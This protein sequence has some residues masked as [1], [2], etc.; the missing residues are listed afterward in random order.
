MFGVEFSKKYKKNKKHIFFLKFIFENLCFFCDLEK[1]FQVPRPPVAFAMGTARPRSLCLRTNAC[2]LSSSWA[3]GPVQRGAGKLF[4]EHSCW[5]PTVAPPATSL[6]PPASLRSRDL[7][8][9]TMEPGARSKPTAQAGDVAP[10]LP[11]ALVLP[12]FTVF[13]YWVQR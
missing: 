13:P 5:S 9:C 12:V 6:R 10:G 2:L 3:E 8:C 1:W 4:R 11:G 7:F